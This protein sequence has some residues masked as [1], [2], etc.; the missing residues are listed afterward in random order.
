MILHATFHKKDP[1]LPEETVD[2]W[3]GKES[4]QNITVESKE[5]LGD[6]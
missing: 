4:T 5:A 2:S 1:Q 3:P 6:S